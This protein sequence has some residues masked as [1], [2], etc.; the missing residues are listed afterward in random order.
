MVQSLLEIAA[1]VCVT[2]MSFFTWF[3]ILGCIVEIVDAGELACKRE[4]ITLGP[5]L[6]VH[7]IAELVEMQNI[8]YADIFIQIPQGGLCIPI[9]SI[10]SWSLKTFN[11]LIM[12]QRHNWGNR[13]RVVIS[14]DKHWDLI[15][16]SSSVLTDELWT[17]ENYIYRL[18]ELD[19]VFLRVE[20]KM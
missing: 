11:I 5:W 18:R 15:T 20:I 12:E 2:G 3:A 16:I 7:F 8:V 13:L 6:V 19:I 17:F 9:I 1:V 4:K 14:S 10:A